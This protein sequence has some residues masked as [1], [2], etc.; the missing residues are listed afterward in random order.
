MHSIEY[1]KLSSKRQSHRPTTHHRRIIQHRLLPASILWLRQL[2]GAF[3]ISRHKHLS[4]SGEKA[5]LRRHIDIDPCPYE[6]DNNGTEHANS[7]N[8]EADG[9]T[10]TVLYI[11]HHR[12]PHHDACRR[13]AVIPIE[14]AGK[15]AAACGSPAVKLVDAEW[16][17]AGADAAGSDS[18][19][20]EG[21]DEDAKLEGGGAGAVAGEL[22]GMGAVRWPELGDG[23]R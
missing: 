23:R 22:V 5:P 7:R 12:H 14:E 15:A 6:E 21:E 2:D 11:D 9:P 18:E 16:E 13:G 19:K 17:A 20:D 8:S 3:P 1:D 10:D 4:N